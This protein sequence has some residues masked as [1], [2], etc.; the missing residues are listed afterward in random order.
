VI[1]ASDAEID[2]AFAASHVGAHVGPHV[3]LAV[4]DDGTG[5]EAATLEH[6][7]E[8]FFTT[9][10]TG[11]GTGLGLSTVLGIVEQSGGYISAESTPGQG[12][13]FRIYLPRTVATEADVAHVAAPRTRREPPNG[14]LLVVE[15]EEPVRAL[16]HRVL[17]D[18]GFRVIVA[19]DGHDALEMARKHQGRIDL[20]F[21]D[22]VMPG[23]SGRELAERL[24]IQR[25][26]TP[27]LYASGYDEE[28][29]AERASLD[30]GIQYLPKPYTAAQLLDRIQTLLDGGSPTG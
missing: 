4:S 16:V 15:D 12:S 19:V 29:V 13:A 25:P 2:E 7:F 26:G 14:T 24:L 1:E 22:V 17:E 9:K 30:P 3:M 28:M 27:V 20:L 8:P 23:M 5:M 11:K 18:A 10:D 21:T 6:A